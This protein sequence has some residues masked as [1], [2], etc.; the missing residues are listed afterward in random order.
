MV[1]LSTLKCV[2]L[3]VVSSTS[4][5]VTMRRLAPVAHRTTVHSLIA[6]TSVRRWAISQPDV[7]NA[8]VHGELHEE[9]Y[10]H[11]PLGYSMPDGHVRLRRSLHSLK[12][13]PRA[14]FEHFT[15]VII[16]IRFIASQHDP[17][18]FIHTSPR[19][20]TLLLLYVWMIMI[21]S[22]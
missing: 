2:L 14:W 21:C 17:G 8:F 1:P 6:T 4:M 7:K 19:G 11:P 3:P 18:L 15:S 12:Q 9:V 22:S 10:M 20:R 13:A 5:V 16:A